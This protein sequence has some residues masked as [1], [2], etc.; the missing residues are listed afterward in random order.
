MDFEG[1]GAEDLDFRGEEREDDVLFALV[2]GSVFF[3]D[4]DLV[5]RP[6]SVKWRRV[7]AKVAEGRF[8][9]PVDPCSK[10]KLLY[11]FFRVRVQHQGS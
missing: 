5:K 1:D 2:S 4:E 8:S 3:L 7:G 6:I 10:V 11:N 9:C